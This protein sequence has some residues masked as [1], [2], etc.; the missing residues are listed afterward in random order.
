MRLQKYLADSGIASR[1]KCEELINLGRV[2]VNGEEAKIGCTVEPGIDVVTFDGKPV[3]PAEK[4]VVYAF[5]KPQGVICS[6]SDP[7]GRKTVQDYFRDVPYRLFSIGRLDYDSEGLLLMTND[8]ELTNYLSHPSREI[9]KIYYVIC[10]GKLD[11]EQKALL[12]SGIKL[13]EGLTAP[14]RVHDIYRTENGNTSFYITI[15]EG[16]NRQIRRMLAAVEH[17]TLLL[18]RVKEGPIEIGAMRPG[19]KRIL[20]DTEIEGIKG[21]KK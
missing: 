2:A 13:E 20:S 17:N 4:R 16:R 6:S 5:Y 1:R 7:Q 19:D 12:E 3:Q 10:D 8:G 11:H 15:H 18:R 14:A 9:E 21:T